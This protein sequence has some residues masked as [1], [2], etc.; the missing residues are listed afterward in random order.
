MALVKQLGPEELFGPGHTACAG[1]GEALAARLI[2]KIIGRNSIVVTPTG[3]LEIFSSCYPRT[4]W[5]VPW[6]HVAFEN[7]A[8]VASGIEA[9]LKVLKR[10]G[11]DVVEANIVVIAGDGGTFDIGLQALSGMLERRHRVL[12][13]CTDNEAYMNTGI[14]RS[15]AT[16]YGAWTT[17]T[18]PGRFAIGNPVWKKN[19][20]AIAMAHGIPYVA[21]ACVSYPLD[22]AR[23][24]RKGLQ[25]RA[26]GPAYIQVLAPCPVGWRFDSHL[27]IE[28]GRLAVQTG[29]Y[30]LYEA[31]DGRITVTVRVA[32]RRPVADFLKVQGRFRHLKDED[33][34]TFQ[35]FVDLQC[36][37]LGIP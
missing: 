13:I 3:C 16:P 21:T 12:Y 5:H 24:V 29:Y 37:A 4:A 26:K 34:E 18:P 14:Q 2:C 36:K 10:K 32:K 30:P 28:V 25:A 35:K 7:A 20:P 1:C 9:A 22:L 17:T 8:A 6:I 33:I 11:R 31:E 23:K 27:T 19:M 15:S